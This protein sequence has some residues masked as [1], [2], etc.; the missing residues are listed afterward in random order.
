MFLKVAFVLVVLA[1]M[2]GVH[3]QDDPLAECQY[4]TQTYH[5]MFE[6]TNDN[7]RIRMG[8]YTMDVSR[9]LTDIIVAEIA[10]WESRARHCGLQRNTE[11]IGRVISECAERKAFQLVDLQSDIFTILEEI[12]VLSNELSIM[13]ITQLA[14]INIMLEKDNFMQ[15]CET[16]VVDHYNEL[17][18]VH[19][20]RL[21]DHINNLLDA[22]DNLP[23]DLTTCINAGMLKRFPNIHSC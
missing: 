2:G 21:N 16:F 4:F 19:I 14:N 9:R 12:Q 6:G 10:Q 15:L 17:E 13:P 11:A 7:I 5:L 18:D 22:R 20:T 3:G 1:L 8:E 23:Q